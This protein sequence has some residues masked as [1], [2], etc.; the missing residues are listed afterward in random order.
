VHERQQLTN[1]LRAEVLL[2]APHFL[3]L[4]PGADE[5]WFW[6]LLE[7]V[8]EPGKRHLRAATVSALLRRCR[9]T[10]LTPEEV[11]AIVNSP[12]LQLAPGTLE[13]ASETI[14]SLLRRLPVLSAEL[15]RTEG[16]MR[17]LQAELAQ[18]S[19]DVDILDSYPG[20]GMV[21]V[22][23]LL[24]E[25]YGALVERDVERLR[26]QAGCAPVTRRSGKSTAVS[27]RRAVNP[28]LRGAVRHMAD[29]AY[30]H[31]PWAKHY[32][33]QLRSRGHGHDRTLRSLGDRILH[34]LVAM[35]TNGTP[36]D[37]QKRKMPVSAG[38]SA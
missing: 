6:Q 7:L 14:C 20:A 2:C 19:V 11:L 17:E 34:Q 31:D 29:A 16:L 23:G 18:A 26:R 33:R 8:K 12:R 24:S 10:R 37:P 22:S 1:Q 27:M 32:Y 21:V 9:I 35:L 4:C 38:Q 5:P 3:R 25:G 36:F 28:H 30:K 15:K 13:A